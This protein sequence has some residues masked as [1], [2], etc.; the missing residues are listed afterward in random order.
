M[1][2]LSIL[3]LKNVNAQ[4]VP[5]NTQAVSVPINI[6]PKYI[7]SD[8]ETLDQDPN[9]P[10][11]LLMHAILSEGGANAIVLASNIQGSSNMKLDVEPIVLQIAA[12]NIPINGFTPV[13]ASFSR[14]DIELVRRQV[15]GAK[16]I[17]VLSADVTYSDLNPQQATYTNKVCSYIFDLDIKFNTNT[18]NAIY[19]GTEIAEIIDIDGRDPMIDGLPNDDFAVSYTKFVNGAPKDI[20]CN[21]YST[22]G[23]ITLLTNVLVSIPNTNNANSDIAFTKNFNTNEYF[24]N[25]AYTNLDNAEVINAQCD[26]TQNFG[27]FYPNPMPLLGTYSIPNPVSTV[28][29]VC[30]PRYTNL[31]TGTEFAISYIDIE[32]PSIP[33]DV[34]Y[35]HSDFFNFGNA[36]SNGVCN[37]NTKFVNINQSSLPIFVDYPVVEWTDFHN[38]GIMTWSCSYPDNQQY[39]YFTNS[40]QLPYAYQDYNTNYILSNE[41]FGNQNPYNSGSFTALC[42]PSLQLN[43]NTPVTDPIDFYVASYGNILNNGASPGIIS[44]KMN[45]PQAPIPYKL[46]PKSLNYITIFPNPANKAVNVQVEKLGGNLQI[47]DIFGKVVIAQV[48]ND[49]IT[50]IDTRNISNGIYSVSYTSNKTTLTQKLLIK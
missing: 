9:F 26:Y 36:F 29:R 14:M 5:A 47:I 11:Y 7:N 20:Y 39:L 1:C 43:P 38:D 31:S 2:T 15:G 41:Y 25:V 37:L 10:G 34:N 3:S 48:I 19:Q 42:S 32:D 18:V 33:A 27:N 24:L 50:K 16:A 46:A 40:S 17:V 35:Y 6:T 8:I 49:N 13:N 12:T 4:Y 44:W 30:A 21:Y 28:P 45:F 23:I 22:S